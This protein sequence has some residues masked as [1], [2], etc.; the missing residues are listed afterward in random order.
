MTRAAPALSHDLRRTARLI[1]LQTAALLMACLIVVGGVLF[2]SV[3]RSQGQQMTRSLT[4]AVATA[5]RGGDRDHDEFSRT[6]GAVQ[7]AV[8][9]QRG[10]RTS[11]DTPPGLPDVAIMRE[12]TRTG[13][14]DRRT[15]N[16][17]SGAFEVLTVRRGADTVQAM[18]SRFEQHQERERILA[19]LGIAG[20]A[21]LVL[22]SLAAAVLARRAVRPITQALDLQR[23][24]V[25]D[26]GHE[27]RTPLTLL[28][29]RA[30]LL[31][32]RVRDPQAPPDTR[33]RLIA[34]DAEGIV[35]DTAA[36][37]V[38]LEELLMAA[39]T[40]TPVP[41]ESVDLA[42]VAASTVESAQATAEQGGVTLIAR[43]D[44]AQSL[45]VI[46]APTTLT[47]AVAALVDNA[48]DHARSRVEVHVTREGRNVVIEVLDDG[49]GI[50][51]DT[52]PRMFERFSS[53]RPPTDRATD[54]RHFGLGLALVSE[55]ATRHGGAVTANNRRPPDTGAVVRLAIP[56]G[57][58]ALG[59]GAVDQLK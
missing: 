34:R 16:L 1:G 46:G 30:Q 59:S 12:V 15:V 5:G 19:A 58:I 53:D 3:A 25:A 14:S 13:V 26:A 37:T 20:G 55:I 44:R 40:R 35:A 28:S 8:L 50:A 38:I 32:R 11:G 36:L 51:E 33:E 41:Q 7:T 56:A 54:R 2:W 4:A 42:A 24:F 9:D 57:P 29:T 17:T 18:A 49:P 21:G 47:R 39:D 10:L 27:L 48:L 43:A 31:A 22:A 23:R 52:L 6:R 45:S